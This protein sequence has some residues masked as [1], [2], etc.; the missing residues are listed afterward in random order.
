[1]VIPLLPRVIAVAVVLPTL[2]VPAVATSR[3]GVKK[4][5]L[6]LPVPEIL[7]LAV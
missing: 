1:M 3:V 7:K 5:V 6:A 4:L 2:N